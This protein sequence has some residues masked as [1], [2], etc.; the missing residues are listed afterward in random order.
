M[1]DEPNKIGQ[2][3]IESA[4]EQVAMECLLHA[5]IETHPDKSRLMTVI[6]AFRATD[7]LGQLH[8]DEPAILKAV[9]SHYDKRREALRIAV[10]TDPAK[11][12]H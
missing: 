6:E 3:M 2:F 7:S 9:R 12:S 11:V 5:I 10:Q 8:G 4:A 1:S